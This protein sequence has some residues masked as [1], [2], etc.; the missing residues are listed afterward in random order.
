MTSEWMT[1][2][3]FPWHGRTVP[4]QEAGRSL[5]SAASA[6]QPDL[7]LECSS[8]LRGKDWVLTCFW[9]TKQ[10]NGEIIPCFGGEGGP[11][12]F[13]DA[14][15]SFVRRQLVCHLGLE[16][17]VGGEVEG[18]GVEQRPSWHFGGMTRRWKTT[19]LEPRD[20]CLL[21]CLG[22]SHSLL[23]AYST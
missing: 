13:P 22:H 12:G 2:V 15:G 6:S 18:G 8:A 3:F 20:R 5:Q 7:R 10:I 17:L 19:S 23:Q 1:A 14:L 16:A 9:R 4:Y 21:L 11:H